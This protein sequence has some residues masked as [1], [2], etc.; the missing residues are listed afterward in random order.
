[1]NVL[2]SAS[3]NDYEGKYLAEV[4]REGRW[5]KDWE[6]CILVYQQRFLPVLFGKPMQYNISLSTNSH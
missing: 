5:G 4:E 2:F 3:I 6:G 1:M